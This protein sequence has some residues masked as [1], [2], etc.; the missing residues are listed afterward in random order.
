MQDVDVVR[1]E[2]AQ[3]KINLNSRMST[4]DFANGAEY[5]YSETVEEETEADQHKPHS[6]IYEMQD[7]ALEEDREWNEEGCANKACS[8]AIFGH[9]SSP[10]L[11]TCS[12][13]DAI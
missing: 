2:W 4:G 11:L 3:D 10:A 13:E 8:K 7:D 5:T 1:R 12:D 9:P 6:P